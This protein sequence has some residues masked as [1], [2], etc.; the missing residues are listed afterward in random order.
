[1][2]FTLGANCWP[3]ADDTALMALARRSEEGTTTFV[4]LL[5]GNKS[6][7]QKIKLQS[8]EEIRTTNSRQSSPHPS[9]LP[10]GE[11][12]FGIGSKIFDYP[13]NGR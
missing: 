2:N 13:T 6:L 12:T 1:M 4:K 10:K 7:S 5:P 8:Q 3:R 9:P 11:G